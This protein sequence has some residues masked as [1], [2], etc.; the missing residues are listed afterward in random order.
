VATSEYF[1]GDRENGA[2]FKHAAMMAVAA[3]F[4]ASREVKDPLLARELASE[5]WAMIDLACP[6]RSMDDPFTL[7]GN[8]R[9]CTQYNNSETGENIGPL[10][11]GTATW[12]I[13]S[14]MRGFG[15]EYTSEGLRLDPV[16]RESDTDV[17]LVLKTGDLTLRIRYRKGA[18]FVRSLG[19]RFEVTVDGVPLAGNVLSLEGRHG[20][21]TVDGVFRN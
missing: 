4:D 12:M 21:C 18:G 7:A 8:P 17:S 20:E 14:L 11:S 1:P 9:F 6:V 2:V 19:N 5:A 15:I 13:L 10:L 16:L 3:M